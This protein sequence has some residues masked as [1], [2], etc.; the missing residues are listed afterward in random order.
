[1]AGPL[2]RVAEALVLPLFLVL[3]LSFH[4]GIVVEGSGDV[5]RVLPRLHTAA[6][7][8][9]AMAELHAQCHAGQLNYEPDRQVRHIH[10]PSSAVLPRCHSAVVEQRS[11]AC[12]AALSRGRGIILTCA[13]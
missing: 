2:V 13:G 5:A 10:T 8:L 4:P 12:F 9:V 3:V 7:V 1:M 6:I 11:G